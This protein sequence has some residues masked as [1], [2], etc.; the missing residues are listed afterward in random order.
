VVPNWTPE[1][2]EEELRQRETCGVVLYVLTPMTH[3]IYS[4]AEVVDDSNKRPEKTVLVLLNGDGGVH[5]TE[6]QWKA[7]GAVGAMVLRNGGECFETLA[8]V[9]VYI[10]SFPKD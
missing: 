10:N 9:A 2:A 1:C 8:D 5:F 4:I 7:Y 6:A 3:N